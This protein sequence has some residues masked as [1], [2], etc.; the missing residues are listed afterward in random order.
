MVLVCCH[1]K[2]QVLLLLHLV[3]RVVLPMVAWRCFLEVVQDHG[4]DDDGDDGSPLLRMMKGLRMDTCCDGLGLQHIDGLGQHID[5]YYAHN[6][7]L[8]QHCR[9]MNVCYDRD[10]SKDHLACCCFLVWY[11]GA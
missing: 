5:C 11:L 3:D 7:R 1:W 8:P 10:H 2:G 9:K 4:D 6:E